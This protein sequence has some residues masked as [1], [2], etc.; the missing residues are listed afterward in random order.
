[1]LKLVNGCLEQAPSGSAVVG[2]A[3][4]E[5]DFQTL[6]QAESWDV[7]TYHPAVLG[8]WRAERGQGGDLGGRSSC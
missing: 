3:D 4:G 1:M 7:R 5:F 2:E 8:I 6:P